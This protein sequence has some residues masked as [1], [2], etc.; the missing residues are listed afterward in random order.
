MDMQEEKKKKKKKRRGLLTWTL[1][2]GRWSSGDVR[3]QAFFLHETKST[4]EWPQK[5]C[6]RRLGKWSFFLPRAY[7][8]RRREE[9]A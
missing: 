5:L 6:A 2:D 1:G 3:H 9:E 8:I 4:L 7:K